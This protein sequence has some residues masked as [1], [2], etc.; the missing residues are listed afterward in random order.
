MVG[1]SMTSGCMPP[2]PSLALTVATPSAPALS[3]AKVIW[4]DISTAPMASRSP[5]VATLAR[6]ADPGMPLA[7]APMALGEERWVSLPTPAA[8]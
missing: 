8:N 7:P 5:M 2:A 1:A 6:V 4:V 3:P